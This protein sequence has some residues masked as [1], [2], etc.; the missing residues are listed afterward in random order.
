MTHD[1][2]LSP[3]WNQEGHQFGGQNFRLLLSNLARHGPTLRILLGQLC[4][5]KESQYQLKARLRDQWTEVIKSLS[6]LGS[7]IGWESAVNIENHTLISE[8]YVRRIKKNSKKSPFE[9][10][11]LPSPMPPKS[12]WCAR[13]GTHTQSIA[14]FNFYS[15]LRIILD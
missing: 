11:I 10:P 2:L 8:V 13:R 12:G 5:L 7:R 1:D 3:S 15:M 4:S 6:S 9:I 14:W